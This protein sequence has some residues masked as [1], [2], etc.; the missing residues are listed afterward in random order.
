MLTTTKKPRSRSR[1]VR[2]LEFS[3]AKPVSIFKERERQSHALPSHSHKSQSILPHNSQTPNSGSIWRDPLKNVIDPSGFTTHKMSSVN[4]N[5][6]SSDILSVSSFP[7][8][9]KYF[10]LRHFQLLPSRKHSKKMKAFLQ[11][12]RSKTKLKAALISRDSATLQT[13]QQ[14][15][16][17]E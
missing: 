16:H 8:M 7:S 12:S 15:A 2:S 1:L 9:T 11:F 17:L 4:N 6:L 13:I 3:T 14:L 10:A 5:F